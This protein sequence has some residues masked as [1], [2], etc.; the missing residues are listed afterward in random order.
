MI[1]LR[2]VTL[3][4]GTKVVLDNISATINPGESVGLVGRNG[5]GKSSLFALL[6]GKLHEDSGDFHIPSSWRMAEVAQHMPETDQSATAFVLEGDTR[7]TEVQRQLAEA[8]ASD[9]GMAIAQA[10]SDLHDAG[11]HDAEARA[12]AL[13]LGLGFRTSEL[14]QPVDSFSGGWRMRLQ[15]AR[16]LMCPSDLLL[17]D[18]PTNHLD[19]DALV[20]L[21][22][23][24]KRYPGTMIVISHDREFLD[25]ITNVTL[26]IQQGQLTRY[27]GNYSKFEELRA[28][29]LELQAASFAKQQEKMAHLQH[30]IDRFKAK[31]SKAKQAQSRVKQLER[32]EKIAPV[33]AEAEFTFEFKEPANLPNPMLAISDAAF[34][35]TNDEGQTTTILTGV[36]RSVLAGQRIGILGANG[37]GKSTLVKT[38]AR[39]MKPLA[40]SV[41]EGKGLNIGYFAQQELDVLRPSDNPLEHMIRLARDLGPDA[42]QP[43][44]EQDLRNFLGTF[45]FSG[46]M[47][48]QTVGTMSGGEKARLVLA[49]IVWQRPNLLLLDEP[50]NHLDLA[51]REALAMAL[52]DFDGTVMLVSHDRH[53]LRAVCEDFWMVGRGVVGPFDG[54]LD[55]YQRYLLEESKRLREEAKHAEAQAQQAAAAPVSAA[56][57]VAPVAAPVEITAAPSAAPAP[58]GDQREQRKLAAAARQQLSEKTKPFKKELEQIDKKM[59]QLTAQRDALEAELAMPGRSGADIVE[60]GKQLSSINSELDALEERWLELTEEIEGLTQAAGLA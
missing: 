32:M 31:A 16:A 44:R 30:F 38:I 49:M 14:D 18:E 56:A 4:R 59:P 34:G 33:L 19:L 50:T 21:E 13:I 42:K 10:Y 45:N 11:A 39:T 54:D 2:N 46:D 22:A 3:R 51:T 43:S 48:K 15:L 27:G 40:G 8:E 5:A 12:Q 1:T 6:S 35:Y 53:L 41:T 29:Q 20:W 9:D 52:N 24:L 58:Q 23:W 57:V 47:V 26:Q 60:A 17:L 55:D 37:Q 28:Q 7:L 36:N 25:A